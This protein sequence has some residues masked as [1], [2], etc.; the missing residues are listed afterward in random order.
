TLVDR[1]SAV[2]A[3][4]GVRAGERVAL[5]LPNCPQYVIAYYATLRLGAVVVGNNPLYT[6]RELAHQLA[7]ARPT[8]CVALDSF[9]PKLARIRDEVGLRQ[10]IVTKVTDFAP[11]PVRWLAP[12]RFRKEARAHGEPWPPV[13]ADAPVRW[14]GRAVR[15]AGPTP[16][17]AS[18]GPDDL[19]GLI[20]TGGTTG[21]AKGA[22][23][24]HRNLVANVLQA[25]AWFVD[26]VDGRESIL[27]VI[28]F[29]HAYGMTVGMNFGIHVG[30]KLVLVP[31]FDVD[32]VLRLIDKEH[33]TMLPGVPRIYIA[34]NERASTSRSDLHSIRACLSGAAPLPDAVA[35][36]FE[37]ITG[38]LLVEGY[39]LTETSPITH[40]NPL[41]GVRRSGT[42]GLPVPDT[43]CR[44]VDIKDATAPG[45]AGG[46]GELMVS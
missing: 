7:D 9:Y 16:P 36:K 37:A 17:A 8:V 19:A 4:L 18:P 11:L 38:G 43:D 1:F 10:L 33:V 45:R 14:W 28:P 46:S 6:D 44:L 24:S 27:C 30:A 25:R 3:S 12:I 22:M 39:G 2:L 34:I 35:E 40:A 31:R 26:A 23:L 20:Y 21:L 32:G 41:D 5:V 13:P 42:I 15:E 29:F